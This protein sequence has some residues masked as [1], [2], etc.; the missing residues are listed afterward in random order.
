MSLRKACRSEAIKRNYFSKSKLIWANT[1]QIHLPFGGQRSQSVAE[2]LT[3]RP[4]VRPENS[5]FDVG[6]FGGFWALTGAD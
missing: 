4:S 2:N 6:V 3:Y 1:E 5:S